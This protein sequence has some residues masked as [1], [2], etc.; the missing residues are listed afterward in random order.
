M[1]LIDS[2]II[3]YAAQPGHSNLR[4][5]I[6]ENAPVVSAVSYVEVLGY[7]RLTKEER[8]H[9]ETFFA[10]ATILP[11]SDAVLNH[12]VRLRQ[13]KKMDLGDAL[14]AGTALAHGLTLATRNTKDF[15]WIGGLA[16]LNPFEA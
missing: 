7:P 9:F 11:I 5:F 8:R 6:R 10:A 2:N 12:A 13:R 4:L 1:T 3:I 15:D 14:T 16:L